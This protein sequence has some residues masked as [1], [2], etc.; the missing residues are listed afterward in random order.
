MTCNPNSSNQGPALPFSKGIRF[1]VRSWQENVF[2]Y[3]KFML[4]TWQENA[5]LSARA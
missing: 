1:M 2:L 3:A 4:Q 5:F